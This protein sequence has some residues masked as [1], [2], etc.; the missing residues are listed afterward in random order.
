[1]DW[2]TSVVLELT[3][4]YLSVG[5]VIFLIFV[6]RDATRGFKGWLRADTLDIVVSIGIIVS[7]PYLIWHS[8]V[9]MWEGE[10]H[11]HRQRGR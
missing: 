6:A 8:Q 4:W 1:M 11:E 9:Q 10:R 3:H 7:W 2:L 5:C